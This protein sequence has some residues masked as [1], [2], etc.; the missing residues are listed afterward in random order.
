MQKE[1]ILRWLK[2]LLGKDD[3]AGQAAQPEQP[4]QAAS[5][6]LPPKKMPPPPSPSFAE[7]EVS[8]SGTGG[9]KVKLNFKKIPKKVLDAMAAETT[10]QPRTIVMQGDEA[11]EQVK[12]GDL[13]II[14]NN[15][16]SPAPK[17]PRPKM[18]GPKP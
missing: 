1:S 17:M 14:F 8:T 5:E 11:D 18:M 9:K 13:T 12:S 7:D 16:A 4:A 3:E 6:I 2:K 15:A 10:G